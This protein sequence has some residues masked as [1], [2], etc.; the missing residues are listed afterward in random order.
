[1][2]RARPKRSLAQQQLLSPNRSQSLLPLVVDYA[3]G[4]TQVVIAHKHGM[5]V[6]TLRKRLHEAGVNTRVRT[7]AL[8]DDD[9]RS[10]Q[11]ATSDGASVRAAARRLGVA[12][13]ALQ[14][15]LRRAER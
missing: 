7:N 8:S 14:R 5:H 15:A 11:A 10:A 3:N 9:L 6:Q 13:A 1:M 4:H 12:H 2:K